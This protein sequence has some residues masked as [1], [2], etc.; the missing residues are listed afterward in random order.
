VKRKLLDLIL[1]IGGGLLGCLVLGTILT[2]SI[3]FFRIPSVSMSPTINPGDH[4]FATRS[5]RSD[6]GIKRNDLVVF[7]PPT[8]KNTHFIQRVVALPGD[9]IEV[10]NGFL[11]ANGNVLKSPEGLK[12]SPPDLSKVALP[13][14]ARPRSYPLTLY[15]GEIFLMGDNF[16][17][18]LDSRYFGPVPIDSITHIPH[19]IILPLNRSGELD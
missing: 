6:K 12:S 18:C 14:G 5:F 8:N 13:P 2:G 9:R 10:I 7:I 3:K 16:K 1:P 15:P 17:N 4:V 19:T 11:A